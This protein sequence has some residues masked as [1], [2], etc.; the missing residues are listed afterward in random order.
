MSEQKQFFS[1]MPVLK[2]LLTSNL[3]VTV[4]HPIK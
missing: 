4:V 3:A 1:A 2:W